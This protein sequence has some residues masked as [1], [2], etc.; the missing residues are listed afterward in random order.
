[1]RFVCRWFWKWWSFV[2]QTRLV[3]CCVRHR[4]VT[5]S[6]CDLPWTAGVGMS[7]NGVS[8]EHDGDGDWDECQS[9]LPQSSHATPTHC[10]RLILVLPACVNPCS[11]ALRSCRSWHVASTQQHRECHAHARL[12]QGTLQLN[13]LQHCCCQCSRYCRCPPAQVFQA[14]KKDDPER[15]LRLEHLCGRTYFDA[16]EVYEVGAACA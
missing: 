11:C 5:Q 14:M 15:Y 4:S 8:A 10:A 12:P 9:S 6:S 7:A 2:S 1:M 3:P 13:P 16:R